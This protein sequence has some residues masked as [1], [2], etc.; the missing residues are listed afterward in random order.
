MTQGRR[1]NL[2]AIQ[3]SQD[4]HRAQ[5]L[6]QQLAR[7]RWTHRRWGA[8][9][10]V[11][12]AVCTIAKGPQRSGAA[13]MT[14]SSGPSGTQVLFYCTEAPAGAYRAETDTFASIRKSFRVVPATATTKPMGAI[15][16]VA[17]TGPHEL[18]F[19]ISIPER[20]KAVG[21]TYRW[22]ATGVRIGVVL[23][24]PDGQMR[25]LL[26]D[27]NLGTFIEP[28]QMMAYA[29]LREGG[30]YGLGDGSQLLIER[31]LAGQQFAQT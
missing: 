19:T 25:V 17:W 31:Y 8:A 18:A 4:A 12:G 9:T 20:W 24:P 13:M 6:V 21:G 22:S 29:G 16:F 30:Y 14:W 5:G 27:S 15:K 23:G 2:C 10:A 26:G 1:V 3:Q 28:N 11:S 7:G